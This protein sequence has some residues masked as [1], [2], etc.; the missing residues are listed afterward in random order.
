MKS[1]EYAVIPKVLSLNFLGH[2]YAFMWKN[3]KT[4]NLFKALI[5]QSTIVKFCKFKYLKLDLNI[6][7]G[8]YLDLTHKCTVTRATRG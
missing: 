5:C 3:P 6:S 7:R 2:G 1:L 4:S 8:L